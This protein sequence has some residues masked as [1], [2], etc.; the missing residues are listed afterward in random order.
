M[1]AEKY[2]FEQSEY[3]TD[4]LDLFIEKQRRVSVFMESRKQQ[5]Y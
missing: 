5:D 3:Q 1:R 4:T 2:L